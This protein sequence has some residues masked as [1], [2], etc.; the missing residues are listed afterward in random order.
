MSFVGE[1]TCKTTFSRQE[2]AGGETD[3]D[4]ASFLLSEDESKIF[5]R[6]DTV[7]HNFTARKNVKFSRGISLPGVNLN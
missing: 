5:F 1:M 7:F 3:F 4:N 2:V 6:R